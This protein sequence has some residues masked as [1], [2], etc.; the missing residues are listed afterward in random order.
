MTKLPD[1]EHSQKPSSAEEDMTT[2][3]T[4]KNDKSVIEVKESQVVSEKNEIDPQ[5]KESQVISEEKITYQ[6][7]EVEVEFH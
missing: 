7:Q 1:L 6:I 3:D 4:P 5:I 2:K